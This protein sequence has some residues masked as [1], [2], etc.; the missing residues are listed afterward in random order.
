[1]DKNKKIIILGAGLSGLY[2]GLLLQELGYH[3]TLL[4]SRDRVGGRTF[5]KDGIDFGG[6]W[7]SS[8]HSRVMQL[9]E[10]FDLS[11]FRQ[12]EEGRF[13]RYFNQQRDE[14]TEKHNIIK[15][16]NDSNPLKSIIERFYQMT[17]GEDFFEKQKHFDEISFYDW[18]CENVSD[19]IALISFNFSFHLLTCVDSKQASFFFW[20]YFLKSC[21]GF[22]ALAGIKRG[23]QEFRINGGAQTLSNKLA[24]SL[25]IIYQAEVVKVEKK[26]KKYEISTIDHKVY[27]ADKVICA[28]PAQLI[29]KIIWNPVLENQRIAFYQSLQMGS[30]TKI[31]IE[32][33]EAFW[34]TDGYNAQ[35]ISDTPPVYLAYDACDQKHNAIV[36][37]IVNDIGYSDELIVDQLAFLLNNDLAKYPKAIYR[38]DW[39]E[40]IF[41]GGCYF[42]VPPVN[43]LSLNQHY[44]S[45]PCGDI[46]FAGTETANEWMGYMEGALESA[47]RVVL[48]IKNK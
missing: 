47:E 11:L 16:D 7:V 43:S 41:S 38:K 12:F 37:F 22:R 29:P 10:R 3:V 48:Q 30:V 42:C 32:Y 1:M 45:L 4:E 17:E 6:A 31:V 24:E 20:L 44:F 5:T 14:L 46:Y 34:R 39:T 40:D 33:E 25:S 2:S 27:W 28:I 26:G 18:C 8:L 36:I 23:A 35:I 9:C 13:I 15:P 21:G 19:E